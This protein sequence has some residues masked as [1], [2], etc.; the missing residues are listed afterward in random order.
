MGT[1]DEM[2]V[3]NGDPDGQRTSDIDEMFDEDYISPDP[4]DEYGE[5]EENEEDD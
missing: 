3:N 1:W 2:S 4:D 5:G